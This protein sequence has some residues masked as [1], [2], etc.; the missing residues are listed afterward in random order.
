MR[1]SLIIIILVKFFIAVVAAAAIIVMFC[2]G[3]LSLC[4]VSQVVQVDL[5]R[6]VVRDLSVRRDM[7]DQRVNQRLEPT[8]SVVQK[9]VFYAFCFSSVSH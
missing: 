5:G 4:R 7:Q 2:D 9:F 6:P 8:E 3:R 1:C